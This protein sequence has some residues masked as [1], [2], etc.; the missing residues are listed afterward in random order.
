MPEIIDYSNSAVLVELLKKQNALLA[1]ILDCLR[2]QTTLL[3]EI[4]SN[5]Q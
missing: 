3:E 1:Q 2:N 5:T 4:A